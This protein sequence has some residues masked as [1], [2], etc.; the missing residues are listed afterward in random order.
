MHNEGIYPSVCEIGVIIGQ[1]NMSCVCWVFSVHVHNPESMLI[2]QTPTSIWNLILDVSA[3]FVA[4]VK[5]IDQHQ[6]CESLDIFFQNFF[7]VKIFPSM[8]WA[9]NVLL[10]GYIYQW[11]NT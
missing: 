10:Q 4:T 5:L 11:S 3:S 1:L 2:L 6:Q 9:V 7:S 8:H